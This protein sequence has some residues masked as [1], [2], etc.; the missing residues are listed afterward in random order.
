MP[1]SESSP[2]FSLIAMVLAVLLLVYA[3][4]GEPLLGRR[5]FAWLEA[6]R[7]T[8]PTALVRF[9]GLTIGV[10]WLWAAIV[11]A[12]LLTSPGLALEDVGLRAPEEWGPLLAALIGFC[13]ALLVVW[14]LTRD[15]GSKRKGG[16]AGEPPLPNPGGHALITLAPRSRTERRL[17]AGLAVTAGV[18]E[19]L[20]YRGLFVALGVAVGM[21]VW[22]AA[23]LSCVLFA[24]AHIYQGWWGLVGPGLL[25]ALLTVL[26]LGTASLLVPIVLHVALDLRAL[27]ST[28]TGRR[29]R[30]PDLWG[31]G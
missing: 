17:A 12:I 21:P 2:E 6:R 7:H 16:R 22:V 31:S 15:R 19:E 8:D 30:A 13:L 26:Y 3:A 4:A 27:L 23:V 9:Y 20:L 1:W 28:G 11:V 25:G 18:C 24:F 14:L 5:A 29:R 10:Q